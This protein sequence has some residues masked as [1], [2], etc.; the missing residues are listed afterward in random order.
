MIIENETIFICNQI[1]IMLYSIHIMNVEWLTF[2][3]LL[4][5]SVARVDSSRFLLI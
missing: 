5:K 2:V 4:R 3:S 1:I